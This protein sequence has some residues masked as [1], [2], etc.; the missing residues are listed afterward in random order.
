MTYL[1]IFRLLFEYDP[2]QAGLP[3]Q[4]IWAL[5]FTKGSAF[6][7]CGSAKQKFKCTPLKSSAFLKNN[8]K[9]GAFKKKTDKTVLKSIFQC[10]GC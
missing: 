4:C 2:L 7:N 6:E 8:G 1:P 10:D 9:G 5:L 3:E